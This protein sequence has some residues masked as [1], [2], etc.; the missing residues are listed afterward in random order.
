[1]SQAIQ[2]V[3]LLLKKDTSTERE[4]PI[5][6]SDVRTWKECHSFSLNKSVSIYTTIRETKFCS[7]KG[8]WQIF[9]K[10]NLTALSKYIPL[11]FQ[12]NEKDYSIHAKLKHLRIFNKRTPE[13]PRYCYAKTYSSKQVTSIRTSQEKGAFLMKTFT[14]AL[15]MLWRHSKQFFYLKEQKKVPPE[16]FFSTHF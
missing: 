1:M 5:P 8:Q 14:T 3:V 9:F 4:H 10:S 2:C 16:Q 11:S 6:T 13:G 15:N 7:S 12:N